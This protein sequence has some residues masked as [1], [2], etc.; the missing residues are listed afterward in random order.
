[1]LQRIYETLPA[2]GGLLIG[3]KIIDEDR[4]GPRWAMMQSLNMLI[5]TEGRERS[6]TEYEALL[7]RIGFSD[8]HV[9]ITDV[10]LDAILAIKS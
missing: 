7:R 4:D 2:G 3:E 8:I 1:L 5:C 9:A 6:F 10:P